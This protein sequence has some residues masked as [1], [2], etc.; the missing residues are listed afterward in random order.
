MSTRSIIV[1]TGRDLYD[2]D[3]TVRLYKHSDGYPTGVLPL[4]SEAL[5]KAREQCDADFERFKH[6]RRLPNVDQ[7]V[8]ILI[9]A[10]TDVYGMGIRIDACDEDSAI[11]AEKFESKHLGC[12]GDL[13]WIYLVNLNDSTVKVYG[14]GYTGELPQKTYKIGTVDPLKY[15]DGLYPEY[16]ASE[17]CEIQEA[18]SGIEALGF[19]VNPKRRHKAKSSKARQSGSS[20]S[21]VVIPIKAA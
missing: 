10:A 9:G 4:I 14:G 2:Q 13:E 21:V 1:V 3:Q 8:G 5:S 20:N 16:Q 7:V 12:Q 17:R 18:I 11:Y 6:K 15:V 19:K